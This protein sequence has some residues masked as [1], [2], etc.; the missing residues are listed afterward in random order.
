[1]LS[2]EIFEKYL[3]LPGKILLKDTSTYL[4]TEKDINPV[5]ELAMSLSH[6]TEQRDDLAVYVMTHG[7]E[8]TWLEDYCI[9]LEIGAACRDNHCCEL[10]DD[11]GEDTYFRER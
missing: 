9:P 7:P 4:L 1:M 2:S 5:L 3:Y 6:K 11:M 8:C 10:R